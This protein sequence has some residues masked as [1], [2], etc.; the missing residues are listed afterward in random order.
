MVSLNLC[1][2]GLSKCESKIH[3]HSPWG[4]EREELGVFTRH[5]Q[6]GAVQGEKL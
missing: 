6:Q 3:L 5:C 1:F 2:E 4:K